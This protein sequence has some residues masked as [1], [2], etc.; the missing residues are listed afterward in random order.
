MYA[1]YNYKQGLP[2]LPPF[3]LKIGT[4]VTP[5]MGNVRTNFAFSTPFSFWV[6]GLYLTDGQAGKTR[7][8][9]Y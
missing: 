3:Q 6:R 2:D 8:G 4:P 7:T 5:E 1:N 9:A